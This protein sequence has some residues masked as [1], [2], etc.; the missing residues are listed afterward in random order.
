MNPAA[1]IMAAALILATAVPAAA[2]S[3]SVIWLNITPGARSNGMGEAFVAVADDATASYW[4]PAGLA[5]VKQKN[6]IHFQHSPWLRQLAD[7]LYFE[8]LGYAGQLEGWGGVGGNIT[9]MSMGE[10]QETEEGNPD[11]I[12]T[13]Y[14]Y[15]VAFTG[16]FGTEVAPGVGVGLGL[17]FIYDHLY[18]KDEGKGT[19]FAADAGVLYQVPMDDLGMEGWGDFAVGAALSNLGPDMSYGGESEGNPLPRTIR[20]GMAYTPFDEQISRLRIAADYSKL[21]TSVDDGLSEEFGENKWGMGAEY[22]YYDLIGLRMG[23][24]H[25]TEGES[26]IS[27]A[28]FGAGIRYSNFQ[29]DMAFIPVESSLQSQGKYNQKYSLSVAF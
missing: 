21:L 26:T 3:A 19:S 6:E 16:S 17:K 18:Y 25:D 29:L 4:N 13:F 14:T 24:S 12:G 15:G 11:P 10:Q 2:S 20:A 9:F 27:G 8:Y 5:F 22:W 1:K 7:D 23:Y 28:T